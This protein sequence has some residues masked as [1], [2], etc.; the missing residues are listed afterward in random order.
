MSSLATLDRPAIHTATWSPIL[1]QARLVDAYA[2]EARL[3]LERLPRPRQV[4]TSW[5]TMSREFADVVG[6]ADEA[7]QD[8][9]NKWARARGVHP[10]E[11]S[12]MEEALAWL[13]ILQD[14]HS[15]EYRCLRAWAMTRARRRSVAKVCRTA[16]WSKSTLYRGRDDGSA[17]IAADLNSKGVMVR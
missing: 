2:I 15:G 8:E 10:Y 9:W 14:H 16:G 1:V 4:A 6:Y 12:R 17:R 7:R 5:P 3:P 13:L 11:L